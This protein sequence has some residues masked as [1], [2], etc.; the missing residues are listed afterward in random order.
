MV[1]S[2]VRLFWPR[3]I[4]KVINESGGTLEDI[5]KVNLYVTSLDEFPAVNQA[6]LDF[7]GHHRPART[8]VQVAR[9]PKD[10]M[11][12]VDAILLTS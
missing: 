11:V 12:E 4:W 8:C 5:A 1:I 7:F 10:A 9:L 6:Y 2:P 3:K